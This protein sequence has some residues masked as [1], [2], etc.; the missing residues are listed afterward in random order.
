MGEWIGLSDALSFAGWAILTSLITA[1]PLSKSMAQLI[2]GVG[3]TGRMDCY[4]DE[5]SLILILWCESGTPQM[6]YTH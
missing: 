1:R 6:S 2:S 3:I 4:C 5:I